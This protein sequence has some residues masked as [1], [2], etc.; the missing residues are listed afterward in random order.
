MAGLCNSCQRLECQEGDCLARVLQFK[1]QQAQQE[2]R[3]CGCSTGIDVVRL[4]INIQLLRTLR[5]RE[6]AAVVIKDN[7]GGTA[8]KPA[9]SKADAAAPCLL[10]RYCRCK[11]IEP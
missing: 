7:A 2:G 10:F 9:R 5:A 4:C 1:V 3:R 11:R 6:D 8:A